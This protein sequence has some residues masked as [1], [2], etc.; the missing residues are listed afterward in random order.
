MACSWLQHGALQ[1]SCL[2]PAAALVAQELLS[3]WPLLLH[4]MVHTRRRGARRASAPPAVAPWSRDPYI[5]DAAARQLSTSF[6]VIWQCEVDFRWHCWAD[7][8]GEHARILETAWDFMEPQVELA[9]YASHGE[10]DLWLVCF[11][12]MLQQNLHTGTLRRVRR[13]L[14]THN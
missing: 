8:S 10:N 11:V 12:S 13:V 5:E 14:V 1:V 2:A 3:L 4:R 9:T 7:Y 6:R